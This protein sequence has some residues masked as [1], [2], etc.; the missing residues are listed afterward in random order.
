LE[1]VF[2][3]IGVFRSLNRADINDEFEFWDYDWLAKHLLYRTEKL[4]S[5]IQSFTAGQQQ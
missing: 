3:H 2:T 1:S 5:R 4:Q